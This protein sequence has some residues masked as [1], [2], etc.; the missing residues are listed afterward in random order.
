MGST[1]LPGKVLKPLGD[2]TVLH[3]VVE[4]CKRIKGVDRVIVATS[5]LPQDETIEKWCHEHHIPVFRGSEDDVL[6]RYVQCALQYEPDHVMRVTADCPFVD[7]K[8]ASDIVALMNEQKVDII[9]LDGSLPRGLAVELL[10]F[11]TL[12]RIHKNG[13]ENR[14]REHVT[15]YAYEYKDEFTR[16]T[17]KVPEDRRYPQFRITLDTKEDYEVMTD[18]ANH[19]N[20]P[21]VSSKKVIEFLRNNPHIARKNAH[22][23]QKPVV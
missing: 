4:R 3:Y 11:S 6:D 13:K 9:D 1:R 21:Y 22:I 16:T 17:Y 5:K 23:K 20:D 12:K 15:Y 7:Y 19:F 18:I 8:M 10:S 14:H 2:K